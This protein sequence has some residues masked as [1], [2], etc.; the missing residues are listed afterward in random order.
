MTFQPLWSSTR[1]I[2]TEALLA[3]YGRISIMRHIPWR[4][5]YKIFART[6]EHDLTPYIQEAIE[7]G[8]NKYGQKGAALEYPAGKL[9]IQGLITRPGIYHLAPGIDAT[10][11]KCIPDPAPEIPMIGFD[12]SGK[13]GFDSGGFR[14]FRITGPGTHSQSTVPMPDGSVLPMVPGNGDLEGI[15][16]DILS[17]KSMDRS[18]NLNPTLSSIERENLNPIPPGWGGS[19]NAY[20]GGGIETIGAATRTIGFFIENCVLEQGRVGLYLAR[21]M[22][23][24]R[25]L[26]TRMQDNAVGMFTSLQH[27]NMIECEL[28]FNDIALNG[29]QFID[30]QC[31]RNVFSLNRI[32]IEEPLDRCLLLGCMFYQNSELAFRLQAQTQAIGC[33]LKGPAGT[34]PAPAKE[35]R[36]IQIRNRQNT[37]GWNF[38]FGDTDQEQV[39]FFGRDGVLSTGTLIQGNMSYINK[40]GPFI[41]KTGNQYLH[42]VMLKDNYA[43]IEGGEGT[44]RGMFLD[45]P[46]DA[47]VPAAADFRVVMGDPGDTLTTLTVGGENIVRPDSI[48]SIDITN[49]GNNYTSIPAVSI[50]GGGGA[51]AAAVAAVAGTINSVTVNAGGTNYSPTLNVILHFEETFEWD[52]KGRQG[53]PPEYD[54]IVDGSGAI[55]GV[56]ILTP[57]TGWVNPII[58]VV[59]AAFG[60]GTG[61]ILTPNVTRNG[62]VSAVAITNPGNGFTSAP[63]ISFTG[64]GGAGAA[65]TAK[66]VG[67]EWLTWPTGLD[68]WDQMLLFTKRLAK[69]INHETVNSGWKARYWKDTIDIYSETLGAVDSG[70]RVLATST[71]ILFA[72]TLV[73]ASTGP[74]TA[75]DAGGWDSALYQGNS[76]HLFAGYGV[77][78]EYT[79]HLFNVQIASE[80]A[81]AEFGF[82]CTGN[83]V[84]AAD[85]VG[86]KVTY[87]SFSFANARDSI[88]SE[89]RMVHD[90]GHTRAADN[91]EFGVTDGLI[92]DNNV[93]YKTKGRWNVTL[94]AAATSVTFAHGLDAQPTASCFSVTPTDVDGA[95]VMAAGFYVSVAGANVTLTALAAPAADATFGVHSV[96]PYHG[97]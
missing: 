14:G 86:G 63:T 64:G 23:R 69:A 88:F 30:W 18:F 49:G 93:G 2:P 42:H 6:S 20:L 8:W 46:N 10:Q 81:G 61:A 56:T 26:H 33:L 84:K 55:T 31:V 5:H 24:T 96:T 60:N 3:A 59:D 37:L 89:N 4:Y 57:G 9:H 38:L 19:W 15:T 44:N 90:A 74:L 28:I 12:M 53:V 67:T 47:N 41:G 52:V 62:A 29:H 48:S 22:Y 45:L 35:Q 79:T 91:V 13:N 68:P 50:S 36:L 16:V 70:K 51:G 58:R 75:N 21:N 25:V 17:M 27:P 40:D 80:T 95:G 43:F 32:A 7:E 83:Q 77:D 71:G 85:Y 94:G 66:L 1:K 54:V 92:A 76:V 97:S 39:E 73:D 72:P 11:F 87:R 34:L 65:A 78:V 82:I